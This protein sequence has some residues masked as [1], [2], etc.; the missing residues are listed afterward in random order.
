MKDNKYERLNEIKQNKIGNKYTDEQKQ[1]IIQIKED[2]I[3]DR[4]QLK[5]DRIDQLDKLK[6]CK[7]INIDEHNLQ[8]CQIKHESSELRHQLQNDLETINN[9][10]YLDKAYI[11]DDVDVIKDKLSL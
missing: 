3:D 11:N 9:I 4:K 10:A 7:I 1:Q 8:I 6:Q 2:A 5:F